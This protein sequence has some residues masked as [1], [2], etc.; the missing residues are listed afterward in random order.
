MANAMEK[1]KA[2]QGDE[3]GWDGREDVDILKKVVK[4]SLPNNIDQFTFE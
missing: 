3:G 1:M 2:G 4:E